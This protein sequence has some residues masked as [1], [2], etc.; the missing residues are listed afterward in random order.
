[1]TTASTSAARSPWLRLVL[2]GFLAVAAVGFGIRSWMRA[3]MAHHRAPAAALATLDSDA[4]HEALWGFMK[5]DVIENLPEC[6]GGYLRTGPEFAATE[7]TVKENVA[8]LAF[9]YCKRK[10]ATIKLLLIQSADHVV[11]GHVNSQGA[12]LQ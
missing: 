11:V 4:R 2:V 1:M 7:K 10:D 5:S 6:S 3:R 8:K 9:E 12:E